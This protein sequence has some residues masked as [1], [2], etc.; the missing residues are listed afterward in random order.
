MNLISCFG[1]LEGEFGLYSTLSNFV[2]MKNPLSAEISEA[3]Q[4]G[5]EVSLLQVLIQAMEVAFVTLYEKGA[6]ARLQI[7]DALP[8]E[9]VREWLRMSQRVSSASSTSVAASPS[10][11]PAPEPV[12]LS[13]IE[14]VALDFRGDKANGVPP[15]PSHV[16][17]RTWINDRRR[18]PVY[19]QAVTEGR[20]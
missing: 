2:R 5:D 6:L 11:P 3:V 15:M 9:A 16:F 18:R 8:S 14:Q 17:R 1:P 7:V 4:D 20:I 10:E 19:D 12:V 13:P